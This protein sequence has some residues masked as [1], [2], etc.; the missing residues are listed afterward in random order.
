[1]FRSLM[2]FTPR[3][4]VARAGDPFLSLQREMNRLFDDAFGGYLTPARGNGGDG[5]RQL[6]PSVDVKETDKAIEI[7]AELPGVEEKDVQVTLE[8]KV[9][10][11]KGE[12]KAEKEE[13]KKDYYSCERSYGSFLRSFELPANVD[14]GKVDATFSKGVLKVTVPKVVAAQ[15]KKIEVKTA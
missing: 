14:A 3:R 13:T 9:L 2:P 11:I 8:D 7:E 4:D 1:M 5:A 15:P 10:T 6:I 12:K